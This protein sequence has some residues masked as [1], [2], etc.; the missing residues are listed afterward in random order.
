MYVNV[1][2]K[3][4]GELLE[5]ACV[6][7]LSMTALTLRDLPV[8]GVTVGTVNLAMFALCVTPFVVNPGVACITGL[9]IALAIGNLQRLVNRVTCLAGLQGLVGNVR[10]MALKT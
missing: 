7:R 9:C 3:T 10:F 5:Y 6:M 4:V 2:V 8:P 1:T